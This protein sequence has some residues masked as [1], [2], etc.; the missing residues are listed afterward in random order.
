MIINKALLALAM[1]LAL[2]ETQTK[3][4]RMLHDN[5]LQERGEE[6]ELWGRKVKDMTREELI[7]FIGYLDEEVERLNTLALRLGWS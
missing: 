7:I 1:G 3:G 2:N 6:R 5:R 4:V